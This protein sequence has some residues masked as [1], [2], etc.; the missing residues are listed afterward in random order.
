MPIRTPHQHLVELHPDDLR[1]TQISV[2]LAEVEAKRA[3]WRALKRKEREQRLASHWFPCVLGPRGRAYIV[4]HHHLGLAL[5]REG[6]DRCFGVVLQDYAWLDAATFW[7]TMEFHQ[8]VH[9]F[10]EQGVRRTMDEI[11]KRLGDLRDDPYRSLV[12]FVR[13]AGGFSKDATPYAEFLW[14]DFF[15]SRLPLV[16]VMDE[17]ETA[18]A[19]ALALA[20][21]PVARYL[22]GWTGSAART[23]GTPTS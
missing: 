2:G 4:D 3:E 5:Q 20:V 1:P 17:R 14:A 12:G 21:S 11:P 13:G 19:D 6:V 15:R 9:P 16:R 23:P 7:R 22:P 10:D 8:W 18:L